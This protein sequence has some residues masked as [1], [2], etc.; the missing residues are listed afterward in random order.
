MVLAVDAD[1]SQEIISLDELGKGLFNWE[2]DE[3]E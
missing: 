2:I 1:A 3:G